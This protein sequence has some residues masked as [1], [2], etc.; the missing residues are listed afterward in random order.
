MQTPHS[1]APRAPEIID[2]DDERYPAMLRTLRDPPARIFTLGNTAL[3][4]QTALAIVG[5]RNPTAY[6]VRTTRTF[7]AALARAGVVVVSGMAR[8]IDA[9]AHEAA[10]DVNGATIAVL[11]TGVD[12]PYPAGHRALHARIVERGL[13]MS[14]MPPGAKA[15]RGSFPRRNRLIAALA[16]AVIVT[17]APVKSGALIT[18]NVA[19]DIG[20]D[21]GMVP[22]NIDS[23]ASQGSNRLLKDGAVPVLDVTDA[24][25]LGGITGDAIAVARPNAA[26]LTEDAHLLWRALTASGPLS[27]DALARAG[28]LDARRAAPAL[29]ALEIAGWVEIDHAGV[30][31][32][33]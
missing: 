5:T 10:L 14:E 17:E 13:V 29:A 27:P 9:A 3:L 20:R 32:A 8:G 4:S 23:P 16:R 31:F 18:A 24:L 30:I 11:G 21:V 1:N 28:G 12:V 15:H 33:K 7:A 6:G 25:A 19:N 26:E 2:A 22:G